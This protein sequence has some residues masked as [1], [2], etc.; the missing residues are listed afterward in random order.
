M[1]RIENAHPA[2]GGTGEEPQ[3]QNLTDTPYHATDRNQTDFRLKGLAD[4]A[5]RSFFRGTDLSAACEGYASTNP[6]VWYRSADPAATIRV[7]QGV[8]NA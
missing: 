8:A 4:T 1:R 5:D 7:T 2:G 6:S 3:N